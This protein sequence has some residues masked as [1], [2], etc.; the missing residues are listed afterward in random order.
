MGI[1]K[2]LA[3]SFFPKSLLSLIRRLKT[4]NNLETP[5]REFAP[6]HLP[7]QEFFGLNELD[8]KLLAYMNYDGGYFV[9]LG[10]NDGITQSNT[11]HFERYK[12][13][14]G[15]LVEPIP[16]NYLNCLKIRST[17]TKI[18]PA[19]CVAF[20]YSGQ[21]VEIL[22]SNLMSTSLALESD[23]EN[24]TDHAIQGKQY[25]EDHQ[26]NFKFGAVAEN[27]NSILTKAEAP[28]RINL[29]SL[30]VEGAEIEVLKGIDHQ[31]FRFDYICIECRNIEKMQS[32]LSNLNYLL[33]EKL[34]IHDYLFKDSTNY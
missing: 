10:A 18:F 28:K 15:V 9:E 29:L 8:R 26:T 33:V 4:Q 3:K 11:F 2:L 13:W 24:P 6:S 19:A 7:V 17:E 22:Y 32:Y 16:Q 23:L 27:L 34:T 21:F 5:T 30:D 1:L 25:L 14:V 20:D 31:E 12:N